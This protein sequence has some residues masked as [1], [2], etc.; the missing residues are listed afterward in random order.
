[1]QL[2][3]SDI[4]SRED[5]I[6]APTDGTSI[7]PITDMTYNSEGSSINLNDR[8]N[9][10][11]PWLQSGSGVFH[12]SGKAGSGKSTLMKH[13]W[14]HNHTQEHLEAW[15]GDQKLL[16][17]A[18]FFWAAGNKSLTVFPQCWGNGHFRA[19]SLAGLTRPNAIEEA[20]QTLLGKATSGEYRTCL[21]IDGLDEYEAADRESYWELARRLGDWAD[22]SG[23]VKLCLNKPDIERHCQ[24]TL[25]LKAKEFPDM[26]G[27]I[28]ESG[29]YLVQEI[30][31]RAEVYERGF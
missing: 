13:I 16:K 15:S 31:R 10:F 19:H 18:F 14:L 7:W 5:T 3:F 1:M 26:S 11:T 12:V 9:L 6:K 17:A 27:W 4:Y 8:E 20:F 22:R 24:K 23:D 28:E 21:F 25:S 29:E 2:R 30:V